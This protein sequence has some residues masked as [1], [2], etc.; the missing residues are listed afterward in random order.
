MVEIKSLNKQIKSLEIEKGKGMGRVTLKGLLVYWPSDLCG[1]NVIRVRSIA[2]VYGE[3]E[4]VGRSVSTLERIY[5]FE[6]LK[7]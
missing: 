3:Y 2:G 6:V 7:Q 4:T 1:S 5:V